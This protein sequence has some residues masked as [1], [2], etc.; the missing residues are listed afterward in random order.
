MLVQQ[1]ADLY[2]GSRNLVCGKADNK[3]SNNLLLCIC[4]L[5]AMALKAKGK[6]EIN[7]KIYNNKQ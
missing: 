4:T 2:N 6:K 7:G 1:P 5:V 3:W